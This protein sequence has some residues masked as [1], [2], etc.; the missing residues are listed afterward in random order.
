MHVIYI[1]DYLNRKCQHK[2]VPLSIEVKRVSHLAL[3]QETLLRG[4]E[5]LIFVQPFLLLIV[6]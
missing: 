6:L 3:T 4:H 1:Y 5:I 2:M